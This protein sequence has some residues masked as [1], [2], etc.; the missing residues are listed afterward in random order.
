MLIVGVMAAHAFGEGSGVGVSFSGNRGWAQGMLVTIAIGLHNIPEGMAVATV[1]VAK[2]TPPLRA[3]WWS[4]LC[5]LPQ[6][7]RR[8]KGGRGA[9]TAVLARGGRPWFWAAGLVYRPCAHQLL[10]SRGGEGAPATAGIGARPDGTPA[11]A[12]LPACLFVGGT[13]ALS[14][15]PPLTRACAQA[16]VA[17]PSYLF[18]ETFSSL[19]P[20]A[21]GFAA[22][23]MVSGGE[24]LLTGAPLDAQAWAHAISRTPRVASRTACTCPP[25]VTLVPSF[26]SGLCRRSSCLTRS[27]RRRTRRWPRPARCPRRGEWRCIRRLR[28]EG[29]GRHARSPPAAQPQQR[30]WDRARIAL[31]TV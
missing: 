14:S 18:V 13:V 19:L 29:G 12:A 24:R 10:C 25:L 3:L 30:P 11:L 8:G 9:S 27:R 21:L 6:V 2:G 15:A 28:T 23:C 4:L 17:L 31:S 26:R 16:L 20:V 5:A 1:M 7:R 22:G